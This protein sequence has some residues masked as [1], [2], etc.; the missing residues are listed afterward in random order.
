MAERQGPLCLGAPSAPGV[1]GRLRSGPWALSGVLALTED[2]MTAVGADSLLRLCQPGSVCDARPSPRTVAGPGAQLASLVRA[3][4]AEGRPEFLSRTWV[5]FAERS[6]VVR[7]G[8]D[9][10]GSEGAAVSSVPTS[11]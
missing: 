1:C 3:G 8:G 7:D 11:F 6:A 2:G 5:M 4:V 10:I 9:R